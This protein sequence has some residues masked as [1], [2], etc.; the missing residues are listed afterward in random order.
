MEKILEGKGITKYFDSIAALLNVDFWVRKGEVLGIIGPN[1]SGKSTLF[2]IIAGILKPSRGRI[3]YK[4]RD[5][6]S[7]PSH[8]RCKMGIV[9]TS[10]IAQPFLNLTVFENVLVAAMYGG[11]LPMHKARKKADEILGLVDLY[12]IKNRDAG[13]ITIHDMK[14]L[15]LARA[16]ATDPEVILLDESMAG[17]TPSEVDKALDILREVNEKGVTIVVVEHVMKAVMEISDRII[18]L[19]CG[20]KIAEGKPDEIRRDPK[21]KEA[22]FGERY[23]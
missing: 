10:Q 6:T 13:S 8:K 5:I 4:G 19:D 21:V 18:V 1:G 14:K 11:N 9:K 12:R 2:N 20:E 16:L 15:E 3:L 7:F 22:Y 23:A 17:L